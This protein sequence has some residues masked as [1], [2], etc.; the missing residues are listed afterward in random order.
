MDRVNNGAGLRETHA[1][2]DT[3]AAT[4]IASVDQPHLGFMLL[5]LLGEH[6]GVDVWVEGEESFTIASRK[7]HL[8]LCNSN[9]GSRN[10][11]GVTGDEMVHSLFRIQL[12][13]WRQHTKSITSQE[14]DVLG[15]ATDSWELN[16]SDMLKRIANTRV[17]READVV[18]VDGALITLC[19]E[20]AS[21][22]NN[23]AKFDGVENIRLSSSRETISLGV[24][25]AFDVEN[26]FVG[27]NVLIVTNKQ[28]FRV[29]GKSGLTSSGETKED[30]SVTFGSDVCRTM[31]AKSSA[32]WHVVM[33][34]SKYTLL[35]L[36][37]VRGTEDDKLLGCEVNSYAS[38]VCD[39]LDILISDELSCVE[40]CEVRAIVGKVLL[41]CLKICSDEHLFH[42]E[43]MIRSARYDTSLNPVFLVPASV[44]INDKELNFKGKKS[45]EIKRARAQGT[46]SLTQVH[47]VDSSLLVSVVALR[48]A[49]DVDGTPVDGLRQADQS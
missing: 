48:A 26:V 32:F 39:V 44:S 12:G 3:V 20:V 43:C 37:S 2:T 49:L 41:E 11:R 5:A 40:N 24:A 16:V 36:T 25:S 22:F 33:H 35:H 13:Y 19:I 42:E 45:I 9:F 14:N 8:W 34:D 1:M 17:G 15:V 46:Y 6:L 30:R 29:R 47:E 7:G 10:L 18:V 28:T 21:V 27:P 23:S 31:H 38:L 4:D